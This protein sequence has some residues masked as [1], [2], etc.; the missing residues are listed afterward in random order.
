MNN[1]HATWAFLDYNESSR[2]KFKHFHE[3]YM[4]I[5]TTWPFQYY[6]D[7]AANP[8]WTRILFFSPN[9][10]LLLIDMYILFVRLCLLICWRIMHEYILQTFCW[11]C[12]SLSWI[13]VQLTDER[14]V[15]VCLWTIS[16]HTH[17]SGNVF[18]LFWG[19]SYCGIYFK[20]LYEI[21]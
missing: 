6:N 12:N 1:F 16:L 4:Y 15:N 8:N 2:K 9:K 17:I 21:W 7:R 11:I 20:K 5:A 3:S 13:I 19:K 10:L 18:L 14:H